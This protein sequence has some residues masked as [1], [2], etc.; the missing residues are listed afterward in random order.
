MGNFDTLITILTILGSLTLF[1]FGMKLM[2]ESLQRFSGNRL[3]AIFSS[4]ASNR[5]KAITAGFIVTGVIQSSSAVT[6]M[7][8]SFVNAGLFSLSQSLAIMMGAN[9]GTT[10][11]AWLITLFGFKFEFSS[12]LLPILGISLP[13]LFLPGARNRSFGEFMLG[14]AILF[15][16]IQ[17]LKNS[18]PD[19]DENSSILTFF[20][21][22]SK[23]VTFKYLIFAGAGLIITMILQSSSATIALTIVMCSKGYITYDAAAAM[24][25]GENLGTT[26]TAN[27]AAIVANRAAKRLAL[28]HALF[29]F[30]GLIWAFV[31]FNSLVSFS[32]DA[33]MMISGN[34]N[35]PGN[36][37]YPLGLSI[38]HSSF[39][40]INTLILA[41]FIPSFRKLLEQIIP[42]KTN[43]KQSYKLR[44][45]K[46]RFMA[47][48]DVDILQ[49]HEEIHNF[50]KHVSDMFSLIPE[51][52]LQKGE[53]KSES[54]RNSI[55]KC[56]E[57]S[58]QLD[59]EITNFLT[60]I[61]E[62]DLTEAN[63]RRLTAM[64][65]ITDEIESIADRCLEM[66]HTIRSKNEAKAWFSQEMRDELFSVFNLVKEALNTMN[67]NLS[68]EY[69]PEILV[70]ASEYENKIN[71][72][73]DKLVHLNNRRIETGEYNH[74]QATFYDELL[75]QCEK[76]ADHVINV[77]QAI[78]GNTH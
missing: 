63:S 2:S 10:V 39:N 36:T 23:Q 3:K 53:N 49:A 7:L 29:N 46:S 8:V 22:I 51:Y 58:D 6:V 77:N 24:V 70:R 74:T 19:I 55:Y 20:T 13:F 4:I 21:T 75:N 45:F 28:G 68:H 18:L 62:N 69:N 26:I 57:Q 66:E 1:L 9:I 15:L 5:L 42:L 38:L 30:F 35:M 65:K 34:S 76:L 48:N 59:T 44:Y 54:L 25:L 43:E 78:A 32:S 71:E 12:I 33:A 56:E 73:R 17:F 64:F 47:M 16:G 61:A 31:F 52:L 40:L 60:R 50:G 27:V 14:F 11:T 41:W 67:E 37:L 72:L